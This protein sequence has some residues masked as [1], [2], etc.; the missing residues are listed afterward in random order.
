V[1][2]SLQGLFFDTDSHEPR[3]AAL[4]DIARMADMIQLNPNQQ[5]RLL[6]YADVRG[7]AAHN[8][9]LSLRRAERVRELLIQ[10]GVPATQ[11]TAVGRGAITDT[12]QTSSAV[13]QQN[14]RVDLECIPQ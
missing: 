11:I 8:Q 14:R 12:R 10:N 7:G 6:G 13:L 9:R 5:Y 4:P 2:A 1:V 3:P